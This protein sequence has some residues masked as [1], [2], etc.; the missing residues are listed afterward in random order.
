LHHMLHLEFHLYTLVIQYQKTIYI[1][2]KL[3][4]E[5]RIKTADET[6]VFKKEYKDE[7][8]LLYTQLKEKLNN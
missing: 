2:N 8:P 6:Y 7:R 1:Y 3:F 4:N 5:I